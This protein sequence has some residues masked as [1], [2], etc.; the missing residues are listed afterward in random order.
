MK[1]IKITINT[2]NDAFR[3]PHDELARILK[4]LADGFDNGSEPE[5][6]HDYNGNRVGIVEYEYE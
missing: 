3:N 5:Y 4:R 6:L 2:S 1:Q